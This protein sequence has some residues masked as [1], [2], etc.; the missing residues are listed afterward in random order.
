[1]YISAL[2]LI[3]KFILMFIF[4]KVLQHREVNVDETKK[5]EAFG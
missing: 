4:F 5:N 3:R 1:M 2:K